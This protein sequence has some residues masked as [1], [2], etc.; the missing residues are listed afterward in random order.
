MNKKGSALI[1]FIFLIPVII[2]VIAFV[3]DTVIIT[4]EKAKLDSITKII[5]QE[6]V[7]KDLSEEEAKKLFIENNI[8]VDNLKITMTSERI[9]IENHYTIDSIF[10]RLI[11]I[12][13]YTVRTKIENKVEG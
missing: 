11:N 2:G 8:S 5:I 10:G 13:E 6:I 3:V 9:V 7:E 12:N 1:F 4:K